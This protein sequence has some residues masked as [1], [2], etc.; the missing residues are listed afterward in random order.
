MQMRAGRHAGVAAIG[1]DLALTHMAAGMDARREARQMAIGRAVAVPVIDAQ[2]IAV[3][4]ETAG[5]LHDARA[6]RHHRRSDR[7][8]RN[9]CPCACGV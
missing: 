1:D 4:A 7:H 8:A 2:V 5:D 3:A 9:R 6:G